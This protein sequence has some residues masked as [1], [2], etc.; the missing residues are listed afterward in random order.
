LLSHSAT[1][2]EKVLSGGRYATEDKFL[3]ADKIPCRLQSRRNSVKFG[4]SNSDKFAM[5]SHTIVFLPDNAP[6]SEEN[7]I[8]ID[9][10][11]F[12]ILEIKKIHASNRVHR[13]HA[14]C[15][16]VKWQR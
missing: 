8:D 13:I 10:E 3:I 7:L 2:F 15:R 5:G 6:V 1:I 16:N 14:I 9:G 4:S 12:E 11:K